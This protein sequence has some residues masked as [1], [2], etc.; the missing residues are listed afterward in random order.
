MPD[1][2][3][4]ATRPPS[5]KVN[6]TPTWA[7]G[8]DQGHHEQD[9]RQQGIGDQAREH[10]GREPRRADEPTVTSVHPRRHALQGGGR[11]RG[12]RVEAL[13]R[14]DQAAHSRIARAEGTK[15]SEQ[16]RIELRLALRERSAIRQNTLLDL[17]E[18]IG[19]ELTAREGGTLF[20]AP[21][22]KEQQDEDAVDERDGRAEELRLSRLKAGGSDRLPL[23]CF[24]LWGTSAS[25]FGVVSGDP[26]A[27]RA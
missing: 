15:Q 18:P 1:R 4:V 16:L 13:Q 2:T 25:Q 23:S 6:V 9:E 24:R 3:A 22:K 12:R 17:V 7:C 27:V 10:E 8:R 14:R 11:A 5:A 20:D 26:S 21:A 19:D